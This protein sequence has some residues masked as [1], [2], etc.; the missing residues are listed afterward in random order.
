VYRSSERALISERT[1][2]ALAAKEAQGIR[3]DNWTNLAEAAAKGR[4][5]NRVAKSPTFTGH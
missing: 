3:I 1:R 5:A 2:V 4:A